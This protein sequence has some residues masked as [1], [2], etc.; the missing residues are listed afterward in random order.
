MK[1]D[2]V[3]LLYGDEAHCRSRRGLSDRLGIE[4]M[5]GQYTITEARE[6]GGLGTAEIEFYESGVPVFQTV[7]NDTQGAI[8]NSA[9]AV[10][11]LTA[12]T[13]IRSLRRDKAGNHSK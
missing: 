4:V 9:S 10:E 7:F 8:Q 11:R 3:R 12:Q 5:A 13:M 2:L 1:I 6:K